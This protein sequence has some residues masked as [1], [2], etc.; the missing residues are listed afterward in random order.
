MVS[1]V[2]PARNVHPASKH[3]CPATVSVNDSWP[4]FQLWTALSLRVETAVKI[5]SMLVSTACAAHAAF[6]AVSTKF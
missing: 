3:L 6:V 1:R 5:L 4:V 2:I